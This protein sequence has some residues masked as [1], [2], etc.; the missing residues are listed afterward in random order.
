MEDHKFKL[1]ISYLKSE[2][3]EHNISGAER[4]EFYLS[5]S[6]SISGKTIL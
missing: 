5:I 6:N 3:S 1:Q 2:E 4:A